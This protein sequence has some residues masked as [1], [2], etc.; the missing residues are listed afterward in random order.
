MS[1]NNHWLAI[2]DPKTNPSF[3]NEKLELEEGTDV[4]DES[5]TIYLLR[6]VTFNHL[7]PIFNSIKV[8]LND[9]VFLKSSEL[10]ID[11]KS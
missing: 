10:T 9:S 5:F 8:R 6:K 1:V 11:G 3:G 4:I 7:K 2:K